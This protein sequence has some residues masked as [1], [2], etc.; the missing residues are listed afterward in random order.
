MLI[1][2]NKLTDNDTATYMQVKQVVNEIKKFI[3]SMCK[4]YK[5]Y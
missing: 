2:A 3:K 4:I 1:Q 5:M